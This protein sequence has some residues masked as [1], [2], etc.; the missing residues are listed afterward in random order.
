MNPERV[1]EVL[2]AVALHAGVSGAVESYGGSLVIRGHVAGRG[3]DIGLGDRLLWVVVDT[4]WDLPERSTVLWAPVGSYERARV[5]AEDGPCAFSGDPEFDAVYLVS[6]DDSSECIGRLSESGRRALCSAASAHP[7]VS[8]LD[9]APPKR[10]RNVCVTQQQRAARAADPKPP[11]EERLRE[12][13]VA[14]LALA[15]ALEK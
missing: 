10:R 1:R 15:S 8:W 4:S 6:G 7:R 3:C 9:L 5:I 14:T 11:S 13:V 2:E 12:C